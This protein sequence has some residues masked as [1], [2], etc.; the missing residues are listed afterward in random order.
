MSAEVPANPLSGIEETSL[1]GAPASTDTHRESEEE[2]GIINVT[3]FKHHEE[4]PYQKSTKM[5]ASENFQ[6]HFYNIADS[7]N[8]QLWGHVRL[9]NL[10]QR[11]FADDRLLINDLR[12]HLMVRKR[13][14]SGDTPAWLRFGREMD[15]LIEKIDGLV[16]EMDGLAEKEGEMWGEISKQLEILE[17]MFALFGI[18]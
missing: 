5:L 11:R 1:E 4:T 17:Q 13:L 2:E 14:Q 3:R 9:N 10:E 6:H 8:E 18:V 16:E 12:S 7:P 15:N